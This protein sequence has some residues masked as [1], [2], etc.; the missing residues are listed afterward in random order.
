MTEDATASP[1]LSVRKDPTIRI[2]HVSR[3]LRADGGGGIQTYLAA[4]ERALH[5]RRIEYR[6]AALMHGSVPSY[7]R[8]AYLG[9]RGMPKWHNAWRLGQWLKRSLQD[10]DLVHI[11]GV[12]DWHF[13]VAV[14]ACRRWKVPFV[15]TPHG[16]LFP[17]ALAERRSSALKKGFYLQIVLRWLL[18]RSAAVISTSQHEARI[19]ESLGKK[20][21][22]VVCPPAVEVPSTPAVIRD[23]GEALKS[24]RVLFLGRIQ[25]I[26]SLSTLFEAIAI[27]R[28]RDLEV[29]LEL[30]GEGES[31]HIQALRDTS[32]RLGIEDLIVWH[33]YLKGTA[34]AAVLERAD[35]VALPSLSE[36]FGFSAAEAMAQGRPVVVSD[37]VGLADVV[38]RHEAG[39]VVP[40]RDARV[41]AT[42]LAEYC[43]P[44]VRARRA[45]AAHAAARAEFSDK[46]S[47]DELE[48]I[49]RR[50]VSDN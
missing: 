4:V 39:S 45:A 41:L 12:T 27:L 15:V 5:G 46:A 40:A 18:P 13:V 8:N 10:I 38:E 23:S 6:Y 28:D 7:A 43:D 48:R 30:V 34:K 42:A 2:L 21:D 3:W 20:L 11:H 37:G 44:E 24:L 49:Y 25:P 17:A 26:K 9:T 22:V 1:R 35:V 50:V 29:R 31:D 19:F 32:S 36:N 33:G 47:G 16:G 14:W